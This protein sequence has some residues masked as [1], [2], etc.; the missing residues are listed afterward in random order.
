VTLLLEIAL[1][2]LAGIGLVVCLALLPGAPRAPAPRPAPGQPRP[3]QLV[4]LERLVITARTSAVQAHAYLRPRL[5]EIASYRL[6][7]RGQTLGRLP[8]PVGREL[9][10]DR[11]W[12]M[13]RPDRPFPEDRHGPGVRA[14][15][16]EGM[17]E[18]L[19]RL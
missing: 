14:Q 9:L 6:A 1:V 5:I 18:L 15:E 2:V 12:D 11:L 8:D 4:D 7:A 13:V 17:V 16:L 19:E 3:A 10:G